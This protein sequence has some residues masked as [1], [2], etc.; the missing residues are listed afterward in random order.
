M[1]G[2]GL[3]RMLRQR[4]LVLVP[5]LLLATLLVFFLMSFVP[6]DPARVILGEDAPQEDVDAL[7]AELGLDDPLVVQYASWLG[8][9]VQGDFGRSLRT[10]EPVLDAISRTL[11]VTMH[12]VVGGMLLSIVIGLPMAIIAAQRRGSLVDRTVTTASMTGVAIPNFWLAIILVSVFAVNLGWLPAVG[13]VSFFDD[14]VESAR[15]LLLPCI[16]LGVMGAAEMA[17]QTR[18]TLI[19]VLDS[20]FV[21]T[22]RA[23]GIAPRL[24]MYKFVM[25]NAGVPILTLIGLQFSRFIGATVVLEIVYG[26]SGSGVLAVNATLA[27]DYPTIQAVVLVM[28]VLVLLTNFAVDVICLLINPA[29]D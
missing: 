21:R 25:R 29:L 27:N 15:H 14:P 24:I 10:G 4:L 5:M 20:D 8:D 9:A 13:F 17:R 26:M 19:G 7:H 2:A 1:R 6:G 22:H 23:M 11:P 18:G 28:A 12:I 3:L 16:T